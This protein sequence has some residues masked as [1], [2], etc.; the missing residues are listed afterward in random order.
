MRFTFSLD[1][2]R[3]YSRGTKMQTLQPSSKHLALGLPGC[4]VEDV[5]YQHAAA[6]PS[7][8]QGD[9][10]LSCFEMSHFGLLG[11]RYISLAPVQ[12]SLRTSQG[13]AQFELGGSRSAFG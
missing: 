12:A 5:L 3:S 4:N 13:Q 7:R 2:L 6:D 11:L 9:S 1:M 8:S 10:V